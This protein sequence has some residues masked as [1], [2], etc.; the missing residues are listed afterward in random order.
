MTARL[1]RCCLML[2]LAW[3]TTAQALTEYCVNSTASFQTALDQAEIDLDDSLIKVQ[4]GTYTLS[5]DLLFNPTLEYVVPVGRLTIRGGYNAGCS[6]YSLTPGATTLTSANQSRL[7][8]RTSTGNASVLGIT[9]QGA[10]LLMVSPVLSSCPSQRRTF[11][12]RRV[13]VDQAMFEAT[14]WCH[15]VVVE[16]SLFTNGIATAGAGYAADTGVGIYLAYEEDTYD[17]APSLTMVNS[18]VIN[19][20]MQL[21]SL[22]DGRQGAAFLYNSIFSRAAGDDIFSEAHVFARHN[23][24]DGISFSGGAMLV[25]GSDNNTSVAPQLD[26]NHIPT[27]GSPMRNSGTS[28]V[29]DGLP[30]TDH[31]GNDRVIGSQVDRGAL[32]SPVD[33]TG[34]YV[35]TNANA[36]GNGS[37]A[38]ALANSNAESG[39]NIIRFNIPGA[40]PRVINLA[41]ALQVRDPVLFDGWSQPGSVRNTGESNWNA[42]PCIVLSGSGGI[43]IEAMG[44]LSTGRIAVRGLAFQGFELALSLAFGQGHQIY[45]NQFGGRIGAAG[46][47]LSGNTQGIGLIGGGQT[48][49]GG[50]HVNYRNLI[51]GS[52]DVGV[53]ITTFLGLGGAN[54][55]VINNLIGVDKNGSGDLGNGTGIRINGSNNLIRG[56]RIGRNAIDG[57]LLSG[58]LAHGNRVEDN[59]IGGGAYNFGS[60]AANGRMGVMIQSDAHDNVI[61]PDNEIGRNGDDGVRIMPTAGGRNTITGNRIARNTALGIDLGANGVS[62]NDDDP[63]FCDPDLGCAANGGQNFP[64]ISSAERVSGGFFPTGRPIRVRGTL[65]S[66]VGGPYRIE[67]FGGDSCDANG[68]GEGQRPV[69]AQF[70][71]IPNAA[72]CPGGGFCFACTNLNCTAPFTIWLPEAEVAIGDT[73]TMTATSAAGSTSEF[74]ACMTVTVEAD[75]DLIFANGFE[76]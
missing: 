58:Q 68:H 35:V 33:G 48:V 76:N 13:R 27:A 15:N 49:I 29:P 75:N 12:V 11:A 39:F 4:T 53:I 57:I 73:I 42:T 51:G 60:A 37:L 31:A 6:S 23:R 28:M 56:N 20:R 71:T 41:G 43:G 1:L 30:G 24:Y 63:M 18:S 67:A 2:P 72:Y 50:D 36:S 10:P 54:N 65:R 25:P 8:L 44:Q 46:P 47:I 14:A 34:V 52:S 40:C 5:S 7:Y 19:G 59:H 45:G 32:E 66:V 16:N 21:R 3:T 64:I 22:D 70:L 61:G 9:F 74:S 69:A 55:S 26:A 17:S 62:A 38:Q